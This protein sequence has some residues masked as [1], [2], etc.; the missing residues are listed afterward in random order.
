MVKLWDWLWP[1]KLDCNVQTASLIGPRTENQDNYLVI[2]NVDGVAIAQWLENGKPKGQPCPKWPAR[3]QRLA[4]M[5]GMGGHKNGREI[6]EAAA[7]ALST[8]PPC[9]TS[10]KQHEAL[11]ELHRN[12]QIQFSTNSH[13]SP[14]STLIWA[15]IDLHNCICHIANVG[16]SRGWLC[17]NNQ[18]HMLTRDHTALEFNF[19]DG[20]VSKQDY[21]LHCDQ[22]ENRIAQALGYGSWGVYQDSDG[23]ELFGFNVDLRL[24]T[25]ATLPEHAKEHADIFTT[26]IQDNTMLMLATDGMWS[27]DN[28]L[29]F[30]DPTQELTPDTA[31]NMAQQAVEAGGKDNTTLVIAKFTSKT[32]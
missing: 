6:A 27:A 20:R 4:V 28:T 19:R 14:G 2:T 30:P 3:W 16:D 24:D 1:P 7:R 15:E 12:L 22:P 26:D 10:A 17:T 29:D 11:R 5:D 32:S 8:L 23:V 13:R 18:W 31:Y 21:D 9:T 25:T